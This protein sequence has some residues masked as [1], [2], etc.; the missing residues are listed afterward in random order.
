MIKNF[1]IVLHVYKS[2]KLLVKFRVYFQVMIQLAKQIALL[3]ITYIT[4]V[5]P[6]ADYKNVKYNKKPTGR[7]YRISDFHNADRR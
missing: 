6:A 3:L 7:A 4:W 1:V 2:P 5:H